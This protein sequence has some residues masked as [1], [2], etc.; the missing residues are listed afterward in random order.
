M[1]F[2][3][4]KEM[5]I[6]VFSMT[7]PVV[8]CWLENFQR[9]ILIMLKDQMWNILSTELIVSLKLSFLVQKLCHVRNML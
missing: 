5:E 3:H 7:F 9:W 2:L 8:A 4:S 1:G 6:F